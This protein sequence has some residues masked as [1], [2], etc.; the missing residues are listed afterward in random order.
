MKK[1]ILFIFSRHSEPM[2][3]WIRMSLRRIYDDI[4]DNKLVI[5]HPEGLDLSYLHDDHMNMSIVDEHTDVDDIKNYVPILMYAPMY[6]LENRESNQEEFIQ[7][8]DN[9]KYE[10]FLENIHL[11]TTKNK[12]KYFII[13]PSEADPI[14][15]MPNSKIERYYYVPPHK[16]DG[17]TWNLSYW[18]FDDLLPFDTVKSRELTCSKLKMDELSISFAMTAYNDNRRQQLTTIE[19]YMQFANSKGSQ[20][21][22]GYSTT[23]P[24]TL[25]KFDNR[26]PYAEYKKKVAESALTF[27]IP[28]YD[29]NTFS[30][31]RFLEALSTGTLPLILFD[32]NIDMYKDNYPEFYA[33]AK[34]LKIDSTTELN[35][36]IT[37]NCNI[38]MHKMNMLLNCDLILEFS[39]SSTKKNISTWNTVN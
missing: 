12:L 14:V 6:G 9:G 19:K 2:H 30:I 16:N 26:L 4:G 38:V 13:D 8:I 10:N 7:Q 18:F 24:A 5:M 15:F 3:D 23:N 1:Y 37:N 35:F 31:Q 11:A 29:K 28:S 36:Y 27:V 20:T 25:E 39:T 34:S 32:A 33:I 22:L 21:F 17:R